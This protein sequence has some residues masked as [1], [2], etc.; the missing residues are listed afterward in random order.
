MLKHLADAAYAFNEGIDVLAGIVERETGAAGA[1]YAETM[2]EGFGTMV[3]CAD[4]DAEAVELGALVELVDRPSS[5]PF[6]L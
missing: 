4:G 5:Q 1:F 6:P 2:H 3:A